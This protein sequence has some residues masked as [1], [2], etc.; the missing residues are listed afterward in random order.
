VFE[1]RFAAALAAIDTPAGG[2]PIKVKGTV[3]REQRGHDR[4]MTRGRW[5]V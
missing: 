5:I 4:W 1:D 3:L 2:M